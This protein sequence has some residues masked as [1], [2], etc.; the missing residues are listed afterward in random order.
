M[1]LIV[2]EKVSEKKRNEKEGLTRDYAKWL[3]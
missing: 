1:L 3:Y 2:A